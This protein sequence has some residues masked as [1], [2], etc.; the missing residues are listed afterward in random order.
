MKTF[1]VH[2]RNVRG[3][4]ATCSWPIDPRF[5]MSYPRFAKCASASLLESRAKPRVFFGRQ[6]LPEVAQEFVRI[7]RLG[8]GDQLLVLEKGANGGRELVIDRLDQREV[9]IHVRE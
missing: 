1:S 3:A 7:A 8:G 5:D 2:H 4:G 9:E 6:R